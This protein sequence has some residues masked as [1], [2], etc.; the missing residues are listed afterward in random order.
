[1]DRLA[2]LSVPELFFWRSRMRALY[3]ER[4]LIDEAIER[5]GVS[6]DHLLAANLLEE[7]AR[8]YHLGCDF[9]GVMF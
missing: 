7:R 2:T 5:R 1:M 8:Q 9:Q 4:G 3:F 6:V